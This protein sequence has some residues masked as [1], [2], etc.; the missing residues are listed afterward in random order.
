MSKIVDRRN[1]GSSPSSGN[2]RKFLRRY[3]D[4]IKD[5]IDRTIERTKI[6]DIQK[7]RKVRI[8]SDGLD[9][10]Y[11]YHD[12]D[13]GTRNKVLSGNDKY[14]TGDK[15]DK[16]PS[17]QGKGGGAGNGEDGEDEFEFLLTKKEFIDILFEDMALPNY[18]KE[19]IAQDFKTRRVRA[20]YTT[21]GVISQ[22]NIK[23]TFEQAMARRMS[24]RGAEEE[25]IAN[26]KTDEEREELEKNRTKPPFLDDIDLRYNNYDQVKYPVRQAVVFCVMD[27]SGSMS[28]DLKDLAKRFFLLLYLF[29]ERQY[30]NIDIRFIRHTTEAREVDEEE[31]F[32]GR[33]NGGTYVSPAFSLINSIVEEEYD[34][35]KTNIYIAQA[36]DGDN[37]PE[38][39]GNLINILDNTILA[40]TQYLAYLQVGHKYDD[41]RY[42]PFLLAT[43]EKF[44]DLS[45]IYAP[46]V[47]KYKHFNQT[48]ASEKDEIFPALKGL[49]IRE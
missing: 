32:Y 13:T 42:F 4:H 22:L 14:V 45:A 7:N 23:K 36:S 26:A 47:E 21:E 30:D 5:S 10:P 25:R 41:E 15:I 17:G 9:E 33:E 18:V 11:Y 31:F 27:V 39:N 8:P 43:G 48:K 16:P 12:G 3:K 1:T 28:E 35:R 40:K 37:W 49:F 34:Y 38:D 6:K 19:S 24:H 46:L 44:M 20:G 2:R 29:I